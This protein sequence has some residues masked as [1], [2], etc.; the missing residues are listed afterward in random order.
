[1]DD[2]L[3]SLV[4]V[5]NE[6]VAQQGDAVTEGGRGARLSTLSAARSLHVPPDV[7]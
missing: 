6:S 5:A 2:G 1:M 3:G 7:G 4:A